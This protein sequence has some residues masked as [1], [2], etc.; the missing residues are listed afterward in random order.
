MWVSLNKPTH[1]GTR[2]SATKAPLIHKRNSY[3][4]RATTV[5]GKPRITASYHIQRNSANIGRVSVCQCLNTPLETPYTTAALERAVLERA[6]AAKANGGMSIDGSESASLLSGSTKV[7]YPRERS[8][9]KRST[10]PPPR[11]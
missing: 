6:Y 1:V 8:P 5:T 9:P 3:P 11:H 2:K 7:E 10:S 4:A